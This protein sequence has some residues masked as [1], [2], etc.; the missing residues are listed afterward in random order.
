M[1]ELQL[2]AEEILQECADQLLT[3]APMDFTELSVSQGAEGLRRL[4]RSTDGYFS[5]RIAQTKPCNLQ[6]QH[7]NQQQQKEDTFES[8]TLKLFALAGLSPRPESATQSYRNPRVVTGLLPAWLCGAMVTANAAGRTAA[9]A[10]LGFESRSLQLAGFGCMHFYDS[11]DVEG[12]THRPMLFIHGMFA[13]ALSMILVASVF[14]GNRRIIVPDLIGADFGYSTPRLPD[15]ATRSG[16]HRTLPFHTNS[17]IALI[18]AL[19]L[20]TVDICGHSFGGF[21]AQEV[22]CCVAA[23]G[24]GNDCVSLATP[25]ARSQP[26]C[27]RGARVP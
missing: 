7:Q 13:N 18:D 16:E 11:G 20:S 2:S 14:S 21:L 27:P 19:R 5:R 26:L 23:A 8:A 3:D 4:L 9:C 24:R 25:S 6:E 22:Q 1:Q 17:L 15:D 10:L 12:S